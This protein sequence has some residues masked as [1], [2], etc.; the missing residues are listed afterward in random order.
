MAQPASARREDEERFER[1]QAELRRA[2]KAPES[3]YVYLSAAEVIAR[4]RQ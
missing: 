3:A 4:N 1:L 2:F